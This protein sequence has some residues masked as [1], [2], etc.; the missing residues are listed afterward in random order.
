MMSRILS[1]I[2]A[3][4]LCASSYAEA[5]RIRA[6]DGLLTSWGTCSPIGEHDILTAWHV[7]DTGEVSV[8]IDGKWEKAT[9]VAHDGGNDL[10]LLRIERKMTECVE[11]ME[12]PA[13]KLHASTGVVLKDEHKTAVTTPVEERRVQLSQIS[14]DG[15]V[16]HANSGAPVTVNGAIVAMVTGI[17][18][19]PK[20]GTAHCVP[21]GIILKFLETAGWK[22]PE[23]RR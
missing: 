4:L 11:I 12:F 14:I 5:Y 1:I 3:A 9:V 10:A 16:G 19:G 23:E 7:V 8:E 18:P 13:I 2:G 22:K 20:P 17:V 21:S 6:V 15:T